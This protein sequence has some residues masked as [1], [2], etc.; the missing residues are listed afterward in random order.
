MIISNLN[1]KKNTAHPTSTCSIIVFIV[2]KIQWLVLISNGIFFLLN[3]FGSCSSSNCKNSLMARKKYLWLV[4][5]LKSPENV[6][7]IVIKMADVAKS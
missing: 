1:N 5:F 7:C 4:D 2:I 3:K 6:V